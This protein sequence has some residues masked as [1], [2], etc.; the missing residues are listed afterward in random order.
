MVRPS[1]DP[2]RR[3]PSLT[4]L[5]PSFTARTVRR[6]RAPDAQA[7]QD[8]PP[9]DRHL[10]HKNHLTSPRDHRVDPSNNHDPHPVRARP[11]F[12][13][14]GLPSG[15]VQQEGFGNLHRLKGT[16]HHSIPRPPR[17]HRADCA[18]FCVHSEQKIKLLPNPCVLNINEVVVAVSSVDALY[19]LNNQTYFHKAV[20]AEPQPGV[21]STSGD[22]IGNFCRSIL[23]QRT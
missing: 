3:I 1:F 20:E 19:H 7:G 15:H 4:S 18:L 8:G 9:P 17:E 10:P 13:P 5:P 22:R 2:F 21:P 23:A 16:P 6:L 11:H 12:H 14:D